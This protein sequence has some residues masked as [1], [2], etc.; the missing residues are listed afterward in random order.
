VPIVRRAAALLL[1]GGLLTGCFSGE[2][3]TLA[4]P[5][6]GGEPGTSTGDANVDAVLAKL[7][8]GDRVVFSATYEITRAVG[9]VTTEAAVT[10][11]AT[12]LSITIGRVRFLSL[13]TE[14]TCD[15]DAQTCEEGWLD[16]R[17]SDVGVTH[18]FSSDVPARRLRIA[19]SRKTGPTTAHTETIAGYPAACV[20]VPVGNGVETYCANDLD[21]IARWIAADVTVELT[22]LTPSAGDEQF[23]A[24][25]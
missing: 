5:S 23:S 9:R 8:R 18:G 7:E 11:D 3:P 6:V 17:V 20:D 13:G 4:P 1:V 14:Q 12:R 16:A 24:A 21:V 19:A 22:A 10:Q 15:L 25:P 2:R